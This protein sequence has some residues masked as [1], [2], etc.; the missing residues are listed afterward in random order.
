[1]SHIIIDRL[2]KSGDQKKKKNPGLTHSLE[3]LLVKAL[4]RGVVG[5]SLHPTNKHYGSCAVNTQPCPG[6][7]VLAIYVH[8]WVVRGREGFLPA[9]VLTQWVL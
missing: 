9:L 3:E 1:M 4:T 6:V 2:E 7:L 8:S 5:R